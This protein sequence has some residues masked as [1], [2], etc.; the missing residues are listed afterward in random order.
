MQESIF[1]KI[2]KGDI[3]CHKV[4]ED[5]N[6][7]AFLDI[8]PIQ[9]GHILVVPKRQVEQFTELDPATYAQLMKVSHALAKHLQDITACWRVTLRIEGFD[10]PHAHVHLVPTNKENDSYNANRMDTEPDHAALA[11][12]AKKLY[13]E[14][15]V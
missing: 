9:P 1:T 13:F 12:M 15:S 14:G 5:E 6:T 3:P 8:H 11:A 7:I 2:I 10:V 4:Y